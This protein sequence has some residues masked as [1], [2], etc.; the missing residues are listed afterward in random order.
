MTVEA[1]SDMGEELE[2]A[3]AETWKDVPPQMSG[4]PVALT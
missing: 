1:G 4:K 2:R 3:W